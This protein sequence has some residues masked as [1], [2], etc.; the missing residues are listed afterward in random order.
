MSTTSSARSRPTS[1]IRS[2]GWACG[3]AFR[4]AGRSPRWCATCG[5]ARC[6]AISVAQLAGGV[7]DAHPG[8]QGHELV[9]EIAERYPDS[10]VHYLHAPAIVQSAAVRDALLLDDGIAAALEAARHCDVALVGIGE[11]DGGATLVRGHHVA[12]ADWRA[13]SDAGAV[14]NM[15]TRFFDAAGGPAGSLDD[16]TIAVG[17]DDLRA[18][19]AV[20]AVAAG[21]GKASAIAGALRTGCV[22]ILVTD[23][24][25]AVRLV[26]KA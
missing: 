19:P 24:P 26:A 11:M 6:R 16:R 5:P 23:E 17:W 4:G 2:S 12:I 8:I 7:D 10:R 3:W 1:S 14:G 21:A 18:I 13:L 20:I 25:T 15:N 22:D 9:G